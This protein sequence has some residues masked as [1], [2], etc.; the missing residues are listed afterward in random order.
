MDSSLDARRSTV[1][2]ISRPQDIDIP[3]DLEDLEEMYDFFNT[4][5]DVW[6][7]FSQER[8]NLV[9]TSPFYQAVAAQIETDQTSPRLLDI[10]V[11]T[12]LEL[13]P[14]LQKAPHAIITANDLT[15][16]MLEQLKAKFSDRKEQFTFIQGSYLD[17]DFGEHL[18]DYVLS[19]LTVHHLPPQ[20][21]TALYHKMYRALKPGGRYIEGDH[22]SSEERERF[23]L[24]WYNEYIS[25][26]Q[27]GERGEWNYNMPLSLPTQIQLLTSAGFTEVELTWD[28]RDEEGNGNIVLVAKTS[29][30][31]A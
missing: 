7:Q 28:G 27:G 30:S 1:R 29:P 24:H 19:T 2:K 4:M 20:T 15:P 26:L 9:S 31:H 12:G 14:I 13:E 16:K 6:D 8:M 11:G 23:A 10:G 18:Y 5:A 17:L 22:S 3:E 21:K 25:S